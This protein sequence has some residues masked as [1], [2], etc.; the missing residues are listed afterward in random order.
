MQLLP[1]PEPPAH[2]ADGVDT[3]AAVRAAVPARSGEASDL[4]CCARLVRD[5]PVPDRE[6]AEAWLPFL[7]ALGLVTRDGETYV[8]TAADLDPDAIRRAFRNRLYRA[9]A[10]LATI[11]SADDPLDA[12]A[13]A[14]RVGSADDRSPGRRAPDPDRLERLLE[15]AVA[16]DLVEREACGY[17]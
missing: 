5:A 8:Q 6:T 15:W 1:V 14:D 10:V 16:L 3:I 17:R 12:A 4:D 9:D 13:V 7:D 2:D 11:E